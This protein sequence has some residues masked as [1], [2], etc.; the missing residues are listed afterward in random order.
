M[1]LL[2]EIYELRPDQSQLLYSE[3]INDQLIEV[4]EFKRYRWLQIG[5]RSIQ[6]LMDV[7][8]PSQI[9]VPSDK[10]MMT[11]LLFFPKPQQLLNI[12]LGGGLFE[13]FFAATFP[14]LKITSLESDE[15]VIR[16]SKEFFFISEE[17]PIIND[18][19]E[20]FLAKR[21]A[22]CDII[23]CDIFTAEKHPG[24]LYE[25]EFYANASYCLNRT[26]IFALNLI[27]DS[28]E[29]VVAIVIAMKNNFHHIS[30]LEVAGHSNII[31]FAS[32][33]K[34]LDR[35]NLEV[36]ADALFKRT[37][38]DLTDVPQRLTRL[39]GNV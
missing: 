9:M 28:E 39:L 8:L 22:S 27:P 32:Q 35:V 31:L 21:N 11:A 26:G 7:N 29:D 14:E 4:R 37:R 13:R 18:S 33:C 34:L 23:L 17:S 3:R 19:A 12:G 25:K 16:L 20:Y 5:G 2:E 24:C 36:E 10:A 6:S 30:L 15:T 1:P 38:L